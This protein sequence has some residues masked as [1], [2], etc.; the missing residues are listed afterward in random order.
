ME[1]NCSYLFI[2]IPRLLSFRFSGEKEHQLKAICIILDDQN[3]VNI[4]VFPTF[5]SMATSKL[6]PL[7]CSST[8]LRYTYTGA[9]IY[10]SHPEP[11]L[12]TW[13]LNMTLD[14]PHLSELTGHWILSWI[15][16]LSP[17]LFLLLGYRE[18]MPLLAAT[19]GS[20]TEQPASAVSPCSSFTPFN[21]K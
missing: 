5:T 13:L 3:D 1:L 11:D 8:E 17:A 6:R 12:L 7:P 20:H 15:W 21:S 14:L 19:F 16:L 18:T 4:L 10:L 2:Q 9:P